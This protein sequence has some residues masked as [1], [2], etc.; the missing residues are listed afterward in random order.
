MTIKELRD[1]KDLSQEELAKEIGCSANSISQYETGKRNPSEKVVQKIR[2][3]YGIVVE[4]AASSAKVVVSKAAQAKETTSK[5]AMT[6][7]KTATK[8]IAKAADVVAKETEKAV[9][10]AEEK[11]AKKK[12]K[13]IIQ[14]PMGGELT[15]DEILAKVGEADLVYVRVDENKAYWVRGEESGSVDLW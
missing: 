14:S 12:R 8:K 11:A 5:A 7:A 15:P 10:K 13:I 2:E 1:E 4:A 9:G 6:A 3:I